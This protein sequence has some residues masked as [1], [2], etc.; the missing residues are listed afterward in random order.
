MEDA[1]NGNG[2]SIEDRAAEGDNELEPDAQEELFVL[3]GG[4]KVTISNLYGRGTPVMVEWQLSG[5]NLKGSGETG[6]LSYSD[7]DL[8]LVVPA[9]AGKVEIDPTY[10]DDG[11]VKH[12]T[13]R[14]SLKARTFYDA[15]TEAAQLLLRGEPAAA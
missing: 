11:S 13:L 1:L 9:R 12:V 8:L 10:N 4:K 7:P 6:L 5:K 14:Q 3:E 15:Q 2:R